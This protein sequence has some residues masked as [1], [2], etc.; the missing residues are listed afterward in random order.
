MYTTLNLKMECK[1]ISVLDYTQ[2]VGTA[3]AVDYA[4]KA[5]SVESL[6]RISAL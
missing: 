1:Q 5:F 3:A 2:N 4:L 6:N